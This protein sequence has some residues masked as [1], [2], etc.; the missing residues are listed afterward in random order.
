M[1][2]S[3]ANYADSDLH[4]AE[5][6]GKTRLSA[7]LIFVSVCAALHSPFWRCRSIFTIDIHPYAVVLFFYA[8][9]KFVFSAFGGLKTRWE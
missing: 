1:T 8:R 6:I 4:N 7:F 5:S 9:M 2:A 3:S